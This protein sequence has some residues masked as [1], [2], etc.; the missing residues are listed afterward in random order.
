MHSHTASSSVGLKKNPY[1][2]PQVPQNNGAQA[3][4]QVSTTR[5]KKSFHA[6]LIQEQRALHLQSR[7]C[8]RPDRR[9][10]GN[11]VSVYG[12]FLESEEDHLQATKHIPTTGQKKKGY[13][14]LITS[15]WGWGKV[16]FFSTFASNFPWKW[17]AA[18]FL[19]RELVPESG[20]VVKAWAF[21]C[22][23][24][25]RPP[26]GQ[27]QKYAHWENKKG[28]VWLCCCWTKTRIRIAEPA[29]GQPSLGKQISNMGMQMEWT[30]WQLQLGCTE[31]YIT[32]LLCNPE[33]M[34][35]RYQKRW[36]GTSPPVVNEPWK[37]SA[38]AVAQFPISKW[39]PKAIHTG[40]CIDSLCGRQK[41]K[42]LLTSLIPPGASWPATTETTAVERV[43]SPPPPFLTIIHFSLLFQHWQH[44]RKLEN[45][46]VGGLFFFPSSL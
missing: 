41:C 8:R 19:C 45:L 5:M 21:P 38:V 34:R 37:K 24:T 39:G 27:T 25:V 1:K 4:R 16:I 10:Q 6:T 14:W 46:S 15:S 31:A 13:W 32:D 20:S 18:A 40:A 35:P 12:A 23:Q 33:F 28:N 22:K 43:G 11:Q 29:L 36:M 7:I 9:H 26:L 44:S 3:N 17:K 42:L 30:I 2:P